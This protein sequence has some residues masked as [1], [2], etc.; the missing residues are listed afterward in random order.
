[1]DAKGNKLCSCKIPD[2]YLNKKEVI[3]LWQLWLM[4]KKKKEKN[5]EYNSKTLKRK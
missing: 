3:K 4:K 1:M 2:P 5:S